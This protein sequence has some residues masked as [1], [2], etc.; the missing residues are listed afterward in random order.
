MEE[1]LNGKS[2]ATLAPPQCSLSRIP[3]IQQPIE[4]VKKK[5]IAEGFFCN[6]LLIIHG[7]SEWFWPLVRKLLFLLPRF[8]YK[9]LPCTLHIKVVT[10][11]SGICRAGV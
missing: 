8:L 11:V 4:I 6:L 2:L 10:L 3:T 1:E 7:A 9:I 5:I